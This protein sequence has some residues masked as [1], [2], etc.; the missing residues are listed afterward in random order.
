MQYLCVFKIL[1]D[2]TS[3]KFFS[4]SILRPFQTSQSFPTFGWGANPKKYK[5]FSK[6]RASIWIQNIF[7]AIK[8]ARV[9][10]ASSHITCHLT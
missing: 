10:A 7:C 5:S 2:R 9:I 1:K 8:I 6:L 4:T 3:E